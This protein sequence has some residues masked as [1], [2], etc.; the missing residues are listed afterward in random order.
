MWGKRLNTRFNA[1]LNKTL[2]ARNF[3]SFPVMEYRVLG[4]ICKELGFKQ[5]WQGGE[6]G[7]FARNRVQ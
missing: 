5:G 6:S 3:L 2:V 4:Q 7:Q 1:L